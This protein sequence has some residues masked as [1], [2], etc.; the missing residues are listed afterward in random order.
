MVEKITYYA[1]FDLHSSRARPRTVLRRVENNVGHRD[2]LFSRDLTWKPS[3]LL[4]S[5]EHGDIMFD[6]SEISEAEADQI[7]AR[8]RA[9]APY[10]A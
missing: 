10:D 6:F 1:M 7:V 4:R 5:A 2:E 3:P 8:I 9:G